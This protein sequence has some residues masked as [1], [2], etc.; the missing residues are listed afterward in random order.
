MGYKSAWRTED[1]HVKTP[2]DGTWGSREQHRHKL[3]PF[4]TLVHILYGITVNRNRDLVKNR[5]KQT[6]LKTMGKSGIENASQDTVEKV[7]TKLIPF[8]TPDIKYRTS[9]VHFKTLDKEI[10][11]DTEKK[12][13][14]FSS[15]QDL[16]WLG[17]GKKTLK[18]ALSFISEKKEEGWP[19]ARHVPTRSYPSRREPNSWQTKSTSDP[20]ASRK[21]PID[22]ETSMECSR[23]EITM[24]LSRTSPI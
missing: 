8:K 4:K 14:K 12:W 19:R 20:Q 16:W 24:E 13:H 18:D 1:T 11:E 22:R 6:S 15:F 9:R 23:G 2:A 5:S 21:T 10:K 3:T 7:S 17:Q